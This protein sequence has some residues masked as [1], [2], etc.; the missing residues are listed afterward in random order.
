MAVQSTFNIGLQIA[1]ESSYSVMPGVATNHWYWQSGPW[2][3]IVTNGTPDLT[4]R[5]ATIFPAGRAGNR[6]RNNRRPVVGRQWSDGDFGFDVTMDFLP[7]IAYG[8]LGSMSS[9]SVPSTNGASLLELEPIPQ[10]ASKL[11]VLANQPGDGGAILRI[12]ITGTSTGGWVSLS[13][14]DSYGNGASETLSF[15][16]ATSLYTRTSFSSIGA[17][18]IT[19]WSNNGASVSINGFQYFQHTVSVHATS[20]PSFTINRLGDPTAGATSKMRVL[21]G[22][23][24]TEFELNVPADAPDGLV[25][26]TVGFTGMPTATCNATSLPAV[27]AVQIWPAWTLSVKKAGV[28]FNR[29]LDFSFNFS[30]GN[31]TYM[32][33]AGVQNPQGAVYL[34]QSLE[35]SMRLLLENEEEFNAWRGASS[36]NFVATFTSPFKLT[37]TQNQVMTASL[38]ELYFSELS[39]GDDN[40][41]QILETDFMSINSAE[42]NILK[43]SFINNV[44]PTAY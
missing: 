13:G 2:I 30:A 28:A 9:N 23:V 22:M 10:N 41:L 17:S 5:Q 18:G 25:T 20:N 39:Q 31:R 12:A 38:T 15:S 14:I 42:N 44:P 24:V 1:K 35:G 3:P 6:A 16:S 33:A 11:L 43:M 29:A 21:T 34:S 4:D 8:A 27:S 7:L 36:N 40:D 19:V 26:G 37:S 32:A